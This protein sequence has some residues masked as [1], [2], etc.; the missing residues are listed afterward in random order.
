MAKNKTKTR[1]ISYEFYHK[2]KDNA[3]SYIRDGDIFGF[4][5]RLTFDGKGNEHKTVIGGF[6]SIFVKVFLIWYF[7]T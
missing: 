2:H 6:M 4:P 1:K 7:Y 5:I 3:C